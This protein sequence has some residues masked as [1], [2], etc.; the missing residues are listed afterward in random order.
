M[1]TNKAGV[2]AFAFGVPRTL[3]SNKQVAEI[4]SKKAW[5]LGAPVYT[6]LDVPIPIGA[7]IQVEY[8]G[9]QA[10]K[11]P[12]TLR[13]AR[14]AVQWAKKNDFHELW[15]AAARPHLWRVE[16]DVKRAVVEAWRPGSDWIDVF[17]CPEPE[18]YLY[19]SWFCKDSEQERTRT[20]KAWNKRER[21]V[22]LM[23]FFVYKR[24]AS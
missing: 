5:E 9:E 2:V 6:Q 17:V 21:V 18:P 22:Q 23:P 1:K 14:G 8:V 12:P 4:A 20:P 7:G 10:G 11:P 19:D 15:V 16:R 3:R 24:V 13:I